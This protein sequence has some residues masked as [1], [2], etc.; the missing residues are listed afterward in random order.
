MNLK[1]YTFS[2]DEFTKELNVAREAYLAALLEEEVITEEQ[3]NK[4][5]QY[6]IVLATKGFLGKMYDKLFDS[7]KS[8][9]YTIVKVI[10]KNYE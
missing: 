3:L 2:L 5:K 1:T 8:G 6:S 4:L 7:D 9:R 10:E